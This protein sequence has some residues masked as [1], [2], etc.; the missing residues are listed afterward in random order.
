MRRSQVLQYTHTQTLSLSSDNIIVLFGSNEAYVI[1]SI[2]LSP[3]PAT[4]THT[5]SLSSYDVIILFESNETYVIG[6]RLQQLVV[7]FK[8]LVV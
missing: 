5:F 2:S 3:L 7:F 1:G 8:E 4:H 6:S